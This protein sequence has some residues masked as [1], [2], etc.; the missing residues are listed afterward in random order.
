MSDPG[1]RVSIIFLISLV[2][3]TA[4]GPMA[5]QLMVPSLPAIAA[6]FDVPLAIVQLN[7]SLSMVLIGVSTLV[8]GPLSDRFGRRPVMLWAIALFVIGTAAAALAPNVE[9]LIV[10]RAVQAMGG[11]A[12]MVVTRAM[13]HDLYGPDRSASMLATLMVAIVAAPMIAVVLGGFITD[14]FGWRFIFY[15]ALLV[16]VSVLLVG[17]RTLRETRTGERPVGSPAF[18]V[19]RAYRALARSPIFAG[20]A[21]QAAFGS[22]MFFAFM[23]AGAH[24]MIDLLGRTSTEFGVYFAIVTAV[25]MAANFAGGRLSRRFGTARMVLFG[26]SWSSIAALAGLLWFAFG[27]LSIAS[28]FVTSGVASIGSGLAMPSTQAGAM[29]AAPHYAGTASGAAAFLQTM[30]GAACV[31]IAGSL[32]TTSAAP[33]FVTMLAATILSV[34]FATLPTIYA[35]RHQTRIAGGSAPGSAPAGGED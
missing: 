8:Y 28:L 3:A 29:N 32:V 23:G 24:V 15:F 20:Y 4:M 21:L 7:I 35:G 6:D 12:G 31:Q 25:F 27:G 34:T 9:A 16:S 33:L 30:I 11:G 14:T 13:V 22:G 1:P 17:T 18:E 2:A 10:A 19:L 5:M 26:A